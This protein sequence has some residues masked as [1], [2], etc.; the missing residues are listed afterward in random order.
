MELINILSLFLLAVMA[1]ANSLD[2]NSE[3]TT[4]DR[5]VEH[6]NGSAI[7]VYYHN[8]FRP[9]SRSSS[10][11][12]KRM[13]YMANYEVKGSNKCS[14]ATMTFDFGSHSAP[15]ASDCL[16]VMLDVLKNPGYWETY[17]YSDAKYGELVTSGSCTFGIKLQFGPDPK[18]RVNIGSY[19]VVDQIYASIKAHADYKWDPESHGNE[20]VRVATEGNMICGGAGV[21]WQIYSGSSPKLAKREG[22]SVMPF[23]RPEGTGA[24][25][26]LVVPHSKRAW[27]STFHY[28]ALGNDTCDGREPKDITD[29]KNSPYAEDCMQLMIDL[30]GYPGSW[31]VGGFSDAGWHN[32]A[33]SGTCCFDINSPNGHDWPSFIGTSNVADVLWSSIKAWENNSKKVGAQGLFDCHGLPPQQPIGWQIA[34]C[35]R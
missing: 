12:A 4:L 21:T 34:Q 32:L 23:R 25:Q 31:Q 2:T 35:L 28:Y 6:H 1:W 8:S 14:E 7:Q 13:G 30:L 9:T 15:L 17:D 3:G 18:A 29:N 16:A 11:L 10:A 20:G 27:Y 19:D 26:D 22:D 33:T 5:K 24:S